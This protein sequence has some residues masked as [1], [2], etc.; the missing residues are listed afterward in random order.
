MAER[1]H[2]IQIESG[3]GGRGCVSFRREKYVPFGGPNGGNGGRG[4]SV[5][6]E[7]SFDKGS[8]LDF[9]FQPKYAA[10]RG[11]HGLGSDMDGRS[12]KDHTLLVPQGTLVYDADTGE[13]L[14]DLVKCGEP[15]MLASGGRGGKGNK[16][17]ATSTNRAPKFA[18]PGEPGTARAIRLE[19]RLVADIGLI[20]MPNAGK[21][22]FL[23]TISKARPKVADYPFTTLEPCLGVATHHG[24]SIV[25]ADLPGLIEGASQGSGLGHRFLKHVSRNQFLLHLVDISETPA[26]ICKNIL[27]IEKEVESY[28]SSLTEIPRQI[29][30]TKT[31]LLTGK[32]I[33]TKLKKVKEKGYAGWPISNHTRSGV[34]ELMDHLAELS[35]KWRMERKTEI[36]AESNTDNP[37]EGE[38]I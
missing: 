5:Y 33:E 26:Q 10:D 22:S 11:E 29:V 1:L 16:T 13:L 12:G 28:S 2:F 30:F 9:K 34:K 14:G 8:L 7:A 32:Q 38:A 3:A 20:G 17:F 27:T 25:F 6:I 31:D 15:L 24:H 37:L 4:G 35:L 36:P 18:Q 21:S 23:S 19:L